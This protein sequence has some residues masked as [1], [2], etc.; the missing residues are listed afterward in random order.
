MSTFKP[1]KPF[2]RKT[3]RRITVTTDM[4]GSTPV[5]SSD[6][7]AEQESILRTQFAIERELGIVD[8]WETFA[9]EYTRNTNLEKDVRVAV[10]MMS[11]YKERIGQH[12]DLGLNKRRRIYL[13]ILIKSF[14][15]FPP[16]VMMDGKAY[17]WT[18]V[19]S[20]GHMSLVFNAK[21]TNT[22]STQ[23]KRRRYEEVQGLLQTRG[24]APSVGYAFCR[25]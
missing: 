12:R 11:Q 24:Y 14:N 23:T 1:V 19:D 9:R 10:W 16:T 6:I 25:S 8:S 13:S 22:D 4:I 3:V 18:N 15:Q 17:D 5:G 7:S 21:E 20:N 2:A